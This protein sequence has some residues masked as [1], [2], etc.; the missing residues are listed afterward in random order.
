MTSIEQL[1]ELVDKIGL[2]T[3]N[4]SQNKVCVRFT[5]ND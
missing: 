4:T 3:H 1:G 5:A 2:L